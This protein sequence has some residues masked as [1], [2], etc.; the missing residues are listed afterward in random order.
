MPSQNRKQH[1]FMAL[2]KHNPQ[3]AQGKCPPESV[4][5]EFLA[6]DKASGKF[7]GAPSGKKRK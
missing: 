6:A 5:S 1:N 7:R 2:C 4:S 3:H